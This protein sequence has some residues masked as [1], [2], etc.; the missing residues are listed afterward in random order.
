MELPSRVLV[1]NGR[2]IL[3]VLPDSLGDAQSAL[4]TALVDVDDAP[5]A[6]FDAADG[7]YSACPACQGTLPENFSGACPECGLELSGPPGSVSVP[8]AE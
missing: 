5:V 1:Q 3:L 6:G 8:E 7:R 2:Y 4:H